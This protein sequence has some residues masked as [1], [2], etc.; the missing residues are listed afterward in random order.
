M[1]FHNT[2]KEANIRDS[3]HKYL[4]DNKPSGSYITIDK[5]LAAPDLTSKTVDKWISV[6][7]GP[8]EIGHMSEI[9][10][11]L[12]LCTRKDNEFFKLSNL[13]DQVM[14]LH[15]DD[16]QPDGLRRITLY[17]SNP[18]QDSSEW[19]SIGTILVLDVLQTG[20]L[21]GPDET[22]YKILSVLCRVPTQI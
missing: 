16:S 22:K 1:A 18:N 2:A 21:E 8:L 17:Q 12:Y 15:F 3:Y 14:A 20:N 10:F 11:D 7:F 5:G 9:M 4:I 19:T 13:R 6:N